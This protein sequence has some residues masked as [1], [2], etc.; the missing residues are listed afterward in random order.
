METIHLVR[1]STGE[2]SDRYEWLVA[3]FSTKEAAEQYITK[4][5]TIY[6]QFPQE[7]CGY[8]RED[9][10]R[11]QLQKVMEVFDPDFSEDYTGTFYYYDSVVW[12]G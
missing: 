10:E 1:G 3:A 11:E 7:E 2:Y 6:Q 8:Q 5:K 12:K 4:L 9:E